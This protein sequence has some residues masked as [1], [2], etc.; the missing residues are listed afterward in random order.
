MGWYS[1]RRAN[2]L[3]R[4]RKCR[5]CNRWWGGKAIDTHKCDKTNTKP[6]IGIR[7][8]PPF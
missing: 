8:N 7:I 4:L 1:E 2:G 5:G 3:S 6:G